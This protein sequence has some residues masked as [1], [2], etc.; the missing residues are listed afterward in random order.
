LSFLSHP[1]SY[2]Y[3]YGE[4]MRRDM[5]DRKWFR[6]HGKRVTAELRGCLENWN[7]SVFFWSTCILCGTFV[8]IVSITDLSLKE[9]DS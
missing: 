7:K 1:Q 9:H 6:Q 2:A 4:S 5:A 8:F 3:K